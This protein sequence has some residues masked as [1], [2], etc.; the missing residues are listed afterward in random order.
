MLFRASNALGYSNYPDNVVQDVRRGIGRGRHGRVPHLRLAELGAE[1]ARGDRGG[2][3]SRRPVRGGHLLHRRHPRRKADQV[4][5]EILRR[6]GQGAGK[7][8]RHMLAIKDMAGLCKPYAAEKLVKTLRQEIGIPIHFHTHDTSGVQVGRGAQG[9]RERRR[10]R[11]SGAGQLFGPDL[12]AESEF[13]RRVRC[14]SRPATRSSTST[15]CNR[16]INT[17]KRSA[18]ITRRSKP[19]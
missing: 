2:R 6:A 1:H 15:P 3:R 10:H 7:S 18:S 19:A 12:A 13:A 8:R 5:S 17:G 16:S 11:R 4:R 14:G 9:G